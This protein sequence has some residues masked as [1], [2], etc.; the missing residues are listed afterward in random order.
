MYNHSREVSLGFMA[1]SNTG[2]EVSDGRTSPYSRVLTSTAMTMW[3]KG[4][5]SSLTLISQPV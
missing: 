2:D 5:S 1:R 4:M 3:A